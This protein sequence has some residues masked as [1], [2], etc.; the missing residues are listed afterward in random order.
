MALIVPSVCGE[1]VMRGWSRWQRLPASPDFPALPFSQEHTTG[2]DEGIGAG[3]DPTRWGF[4]LGN[5]FLLRAKAPPHP[6]H[7]SH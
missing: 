6:S 4:G 3:K 5:Q 1:S 2:L 7:R